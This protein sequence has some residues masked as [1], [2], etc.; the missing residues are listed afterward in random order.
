MIIVKGAGDKAFCA[1][2]DVIGLF[3]SFRN[4]LVVAVSKSG[5]EAQ[6]GKGDSTMHKD[7]FRE[8][9]ILNHLI[10]TLRKPYIAIIDGIVMGGVSSFLN[11]TTVFV[12]MWAICKRKIPCFYGKNNASNARDCF[13]S[14]P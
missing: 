2:G 12:G 4:M 10:G 6:T 3:A 11:K 13:G 9:Y 5:K 14:F 1:G 8:E 7:F